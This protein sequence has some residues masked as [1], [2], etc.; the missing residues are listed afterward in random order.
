MVE[1]EKIDYVEFPARDIRVAKAFFSGVFGWTFEDY[2]PDY[3]AFSNG[4][5]DGGFY[6]SDL[7][8][9]TANGGALII[10]YSKELE[11]TQSKIEN[12]GGSII[13]PI[14]SF[15]GGRR[16][17]FGDPNGNEYAVWSDVI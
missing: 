2:G 8:A 7:T 11:S 17:H 5:V 6:K 1:H 10:F 13:R 12:T 16:F 14:Y 4:G 3:A 9:S 15:P